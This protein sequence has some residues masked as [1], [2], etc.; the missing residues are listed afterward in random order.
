MNGW[1]QQKTGT[2][3]MMTPLS[4]AYDLWDHKL[5]LEKA[6]LMGL[7][8]HGADGALFMRESRHFAKSDK[9]A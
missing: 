6:R 5:D 9:T 4:A 8:E 1:Q 3:I 2:G 7:T